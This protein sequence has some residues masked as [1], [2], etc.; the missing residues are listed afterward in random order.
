MVRGAACDE[1]EPARATE[2]G[3]VVTKP[4]QLD[5][6]G[7]KPPAQSVGNRVDLL[8]NLFEHEV[9]ERALLD[10]FESNVE[11]LHVAGGLNHRLGDH[12]S[13]G[14][15]RAVVDDA[16]A[17]DKVADLIVL[18]VNDLVGVLDDRRRVGRHVVL[19]RVQILRSGRRR[20]HGNIRAHDSRR[21]RFAGTERI[22][23]RRV[24]WNVLRAIQR[25]ALAEEARAAAAERTALSE[26]RE[27]APEICV[28]GSATAER[29]VE[30]RGR[31]SEVDGAR[32]TERPATHLDGRNSR[33]RGRVRD[34]LVHIRGKAHANN[35]RRAD[36]GTNHL[37]LVVRRGHND[38]VRARENR[39]HDRRQLGKRRRAAAAFNEPVVLVKV[40]L[41]NDLGVSVRLKDVAIRLEQSLK[42]LVVVDDAVVDDD[43]LVLG[44]RA[45]GVR[46]DRRRRAVS[47]PASVRQAFVLLKHAPV[48]ER[49]RRGNER[50][51][52]R[53]EPDL[54]EQNRLAGI[55]SHRETSRVVAAIL[56]ALEATEE[57]LDDLLTLT[58]HQMVEKS[59]NS[60]H[61]KAERRERKR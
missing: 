2:I 18:H 5:G 51:Q 24:E 58:R 17:L 44:V 40:E 4:S 1:N 45:M 14:V 38:G 60:T 25:R 47:R 22:A 10:R 35:H 27:H 56:E 13:A 61:C 19:D 3:K 41:G 54:L 21:S 30:T 32:C 31:A 33:E 46:V 12:D 26:V 36:L 43:E 39:H 8:V 59:E 6:V 42:L 50:L 9:L 7:K 11:L 15:A 28:C 23:D 29:G 48:V 57:N 20:R 34:L 53:N 52:T 37:V 55:S 16:I 49:R